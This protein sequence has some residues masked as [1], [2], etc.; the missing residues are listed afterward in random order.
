MSVAASDPQGHMLYHASSTD[1]D[2][3]SSVISA[4]TQQPCGVETHNNNAD[5]LRRHEISPCDRMKE[6]TLTHITVPYSGFSP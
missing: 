2:G 6:A 1:T 5:M 4:D 3:D